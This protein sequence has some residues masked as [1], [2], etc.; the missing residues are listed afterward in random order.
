M[1]GSLS[2]PLHNDA[3]RTSKERQSGSSMLVSLR[4]MYFHPA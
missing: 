4:H 3:P 1:T 2:F